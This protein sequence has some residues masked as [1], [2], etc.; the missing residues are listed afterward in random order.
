MPNPRR[1][2]KKKPTKRNA[3]R[4][5]ADTSQQR[6]LGGL[7]KGPSL[8]DLKPQVE[9]KQRSPK[10]PAAD[11]AEIGARRA[12]ANGDASRMLTSTDPK[13]LLQELMMV[14]GAVAKGWNIR[15]KDMIRDRLLKIMRKETAEVFT[16]E[17]AVESETAA[18]ELAIK[19]AKV[20]ESMDASDVKRLE[21]INDIVTKKNAQP[22]PSTEI[23]INVNGQQ[24]ASSLTSTEEGRSQLLALAKRFGASE[25]VIEDRP[26]IQASPG[27]TDSDLS[28]DADS[29]PGNWPTNDS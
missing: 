7:G 3:S 6:L 11:L 9:Q 21:V 15:Q 2:H 18:D 10:K 12:K 22:G 19:A 17:G 16:K 26:V 28:G 5:P 20:L 1:G 27:E 13:E 4:K 29:S 25:L 8:N 23:N 24:Q 14:Q